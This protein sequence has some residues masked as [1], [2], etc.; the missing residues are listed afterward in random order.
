MVL[1]IVANVINGMIAGDLTDRETSRT[2]LTPSGYAI[3]A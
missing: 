3:F 1:K 2:F